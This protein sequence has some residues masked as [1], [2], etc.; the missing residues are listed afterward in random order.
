MMGL[1]MKKKSIS[2]CLKHVCSS[3]MMASL[4]MTAKVSWCSVLTRMG[5][6]LVT[7]VNTFSWTPMAAVC[8]PS[9]ERY[10]PPSLALSLSLSLYIYIYIYIYIWINDLTQP[11]LSCLLNWAIGVFRSSWTFSFLCFSFKKKIPKWRV[12]NWIV[13]IFGDFN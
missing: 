3:L 7:R 2:Q 10:Y 13:S 5:L 6:T 4:S 8:S 11:V 9:E 12:P 1:S